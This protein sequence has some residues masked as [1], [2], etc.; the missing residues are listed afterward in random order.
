MSEQKSN[1]PATYFERD[2]IIKLARLTEIFS[3]AV[4]GYAVVQSAFSIFVFILQF[5]RGLLVFNG[6]TDIIQQVFWFLQPIAPA[7]MQFAVIQGIGKALLIFM[8][9]EDNLRRAA[10][11]KSA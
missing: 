9:V 5:V 8:D 2:A 3:W 10:R 7:M 6:P 11:N 1:F 4:L